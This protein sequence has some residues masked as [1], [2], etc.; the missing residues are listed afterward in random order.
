MTHSFWSFALHQSCSIHLDLDM[1]QVIY[2][3][4]FSLGLSVVFF[5][6]SFFLEL[7][8]EELWFEEMMMLDMRVK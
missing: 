2:W 5:F 4:G 3:R 1:I 7:E 8:F 6:C